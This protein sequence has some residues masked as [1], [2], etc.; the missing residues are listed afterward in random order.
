[1]SKIGTEILVNEQTFYDQNSPQ[2]AKLNNGGFVTVWVDWADRID[3]SVADGSWS[4]IK[5]QVF[6]GQ[7]TKKG[8]EILVN[9]ATL[10]WQQDPHV[11]VLQN[12][13]FVVT[14]T[15]GWDYFAW[16]DHPGSLGVGGATGDEEGKAIKA[17]FFSASGAKIGTEILVNTEH[18]SS[19]TG[20]KTV[21]LAEGTFVV[22]W[23]DWS[24]SCNYDPDGTLESCG[25]GP[26]IKA[27]LF[28]SA[29]GKIGTELLVAGE[30]N[31]SPQITALIDGG[32]VVAW[33][34]NHYSVQDV[35]VQVFNAAGVAVGSHTLVNTA[36]KGATFST[37]FEQQVV[38]LSN[39]GFVVT[40]TDKN[41]DDSSYGVKAQVFDAAGDKISTEILVNTYTTSYQQHPQLVALTN[42]GFVVAW[43][44]WGSEDVNAQIFDD[45]GG[46]VGSEILVN[47]ATGNHQLY[48]QVAA[49]DCGG[50]AVS[51]W[52]YL[53]YAPKTQ[54][55]DALGSKIGSEVLANTTPAVSGACPITALDDGTFVVN[56][57]ARDDSGTAVKA[58]VFDTNPVPAGQILNGTAGN[59]TL[60]GGF[61]DDTIDGGDGVDVLVL[62]GLPSQYQLNA[63]E[64]TGIEGTDVVTGLEKYRFGSSLDDDAYMSDIC[65]CAL[66]DPDGDGPGDSR[67]TDMLQGIS[68]LYVAY[69]N[70]APDVKGLMY[71]FEEVINGSTWTLATI[72]QSFTDQAEYRETYPI[73]LSNSE[74]VN[75]IYQNLFDRAPEPA[76]LAY[77]VNDLNQGVPRDVF[78]YSVIQGAYAPSGGTSDRALLNNKHDVS[79]YY[80]EQLATHAEAFDNQID[81]VL[82]R[83]TDEIETV[84]RAKEVIDFVI[85]DPLTLSGLI[86]ETATWEAFWV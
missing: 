8:S 44:N 28:N 17:Q 61:G 45:S 75:A 73:G 38:G 62:S 43:D 34:D 46:R 13:N 30:Y 56:W 31:Y 78:I 65:P 71:W 52:D 53:E 36:G 26:Q 74:F 18:R 3:P 50:F 47:T 69:F 70:R 76:G 6:S 25:G 68:D 21:V 16:A 14:W 23:E 35:Y 64:L 57:I 83:V 9:A 72:A 33:L 41:G 11:T 12:G 29:G 27:Q 32:F 66:V 79:L 55:F 48:A 7:G 51:W 81:Q 37:Q 19:Q 82:N 39:G 84:A 63:T 15:D 58:Q 24:S 40:W 20:Q 10:N 60:T 54:V 49:L 4:G 86:S 22:T 1:M 85:A 42:G 67:A 5:A 80:S 77:W 2:S 59:D